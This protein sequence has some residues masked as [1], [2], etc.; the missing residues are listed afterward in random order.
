MEAEGPWIRSGAS[1][2]VEHWQVASIERNTQPRELKSRR[3]DVVQSQE[4][5]RH[6]R[7]VSAGENEGCRQNYEA[8]LNWSKADLIRSC[9]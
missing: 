5:H 7:Q 9:K 3:K 6:G 1:A 4:Q 2:E 8:R